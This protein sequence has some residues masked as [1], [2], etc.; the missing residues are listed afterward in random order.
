MEVRKEEKEQKRE[1]TG[2]KSRGVKGEKILETLAQTQTYTRLSHLLTG[3]KKDPL[4]PLLPGSRTH[5]TTAF[6]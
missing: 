2:K 5:V 6:S 3:E 1:K 4:S